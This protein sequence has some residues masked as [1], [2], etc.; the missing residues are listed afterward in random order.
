M[1]QARGTSDCPSAL[2]TSSLT[3]QVLSGGVDAGEGAS[4]LHHVVRARV[5]PLDV[6]GVHLAEHLVTRSCRVVIGN[7]H[8]KKGTI[9][10]ERCCTA[11]ARHNPL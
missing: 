8:N 4:G 10:G 9:R 6:S 5:A 2:G 1:E 11:A 7:R 3:R